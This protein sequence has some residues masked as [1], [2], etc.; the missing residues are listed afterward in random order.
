MNKCA[1]CGKF[2]SLDN[3]NN[4]YIFTPDTDYSCEESYWICEKCDKENKKYE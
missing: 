2:I 3:K 4:H 1:H